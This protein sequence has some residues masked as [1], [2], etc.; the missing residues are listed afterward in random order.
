MSVPAFPCDQLVLKRRD[1]VC[2]QTFAL[3][4]FAFLVHGFLEAFQVLWSLCPGGSSHNIWVSD[5]IEESMAVVKME[6]IKRIK[7]HLSCISF[8][9]IPI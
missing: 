3:L 4:C 1:R 8:R 5:K 2:N 9:L 7:C 6:V